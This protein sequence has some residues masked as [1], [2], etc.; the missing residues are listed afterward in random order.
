[1]PRLDRLISDLIRLKS[2]GSD[3]RMSWVYSGE[4]WVRLGGRA[5]WRRVLM[6][7]W[8]GGGLIV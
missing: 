5:Y 2:S 3:W 8:R 4:A 6:M 7:F 1:M